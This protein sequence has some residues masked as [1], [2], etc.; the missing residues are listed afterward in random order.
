MEIKYF[1]EESIKEIEKYCN[2]EDPSDSKLFHYILWKVNNLKCER[3]VIEYDYIDR[4]FSADY[5]SYYSTIFQESGKY[6]CRIHF[7][8]NFE[9]DFPFDEKRDENFRINL[10]ALKEAY[11]G[12]IVILPTTVKVIG[13]TVIK[14]Y[15]HDVTKCCY[16]T[17]RCATTVNIQGIPFSIE[18]MPFIQKDENVGVCASTSIWMVSNYMNARF[19]FQRHSLSQITFIANKYQRHNR[20]YPAM[21]GLDVKQIITGFAELG[22]D[23]II[24]YD[25]KTFHREKWKPKEIIYKY[26]ESE[27]PVIA[28]IQGRHAC[29]VIGHDFDPH[30]NIPKTHNI[31]SN[32][33]FI[34]SFLIHDDDRGPFKLLP[35]I[36]NISN[37]GGDYEINDKHNSF[38]E[39]PNVYSLYT[40]N[41]IT[42][43]IIP[44]FN[45]I[46]LEGPAVDDLI[47][48]IFSDS[49]DKS[50]FNYYSRMISVLEKSTDLE[51][52][53][54]ELARKFLDSINN[55][56]IFYR[57]RFVLS[58][59]L[60]ENYLLLKSKV[61]FALGD[62]YSKMNLPR[63]VWL[64]ELFFEDDLKN[65][66]M[67]ESD[68][69]IVIGEILID[70]TGIDRLSSIIS[71]HFPGFLIIFNSL[72]FPTEMDEGEIFRFNVIQNDVPYE[73]YGRY[74]N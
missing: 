18:S 60:K 44:I 13:R 48:S 71:V 5:A 43:I 42:N 4:D 34:R 35:E 55:G 14:P 46:Y 57:S 23:S 21:R 63:Y 1:N 12:F 56:R 15:I 49:S 24:H 17:V 69:D 31:I 70:A 68:I 11:L 22:Y 30:K 16:C 20:M 52:K 39:S 74:A 8:S 32:A 28:V 2:I 65:K 62:S 51:I 36:P 72:Y 67:L 73:L 45:K 61:P 38:K 27:L 40:M 37:N 66:M 47:T 6:C 3:I 9:G 26:I 54:I 19:G 25:R 58:N 10:P 33:V 53:T 7:F 59:H 50:I 64:T 41:G 29:V